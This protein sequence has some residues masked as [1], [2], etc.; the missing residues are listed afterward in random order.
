MTQFYKRMGL[1]A[2]AQR[3]TLVALVGA[4]TASAA[5]AQLGHTPSYTQNLNT[6]YTDL[7]TT[8]TAIATANNDDANSAEQ[9]IGFTFSFDGLVMDRFILNT[10]GFLKLG[11]AAGMAAPTVAQYTEFAQSNSGG[12]LLGTAA[13]DVELLSPFNYDL[14]NGTSPAEFRVAT[15]GTA[16][17][18]VCTVQ[19]KNVADK[20]QLTAAGGTSVANQYANLSFQVRMFETSNTIEFVYGPNTPAPAANND[21]KYAQVGIKGAGSVA[22][23]ILQVAKISATPW[24]DQTGVTFAN[25]PVMAGPVGAFNFRQAAPPDNGRT[26]RFAVPVPNDVAVSAIQGFASVIVPA[27]GAIT[28]RGVISNLG[29]AAQSVAIPVTLTISGANTYTATQRLV[30]LAV[31]ASGVVTFPGISLPNVGQNTVTLSVPSDGNN[32]NNTVAQPME[33][34][35]TTF[36]LATPGGG[37]LPTGFNPGTERY[38]A[39]KMTLNTPRSITAVSG[40]ITN[41]GNAPTSKESIGES[42][43]GVVIDAA[44]GALLGRSPN[45]VIMAADVNVLH[46]FTLSAPTTVPAGDVLVG[47]VLTASTGTLPYY[48]F[49]VQAEDPNRAGTYYIGTPGIAPTPALNV[50]GQTGYKFPFGAVTGAPANNDFSVNEIQAY[51]SIAVPAGNPVTL[52]AVVR[53]GGLLA[54]AAPLAVTLTVSGANSVTQTQ[55]VTSLAVGATT[56][57]TFTSLNLSSA[58]ANT[59][60]VT[61]PTDD[62]NAN[63]SMAQPMATSATRF[64]TIAPGGTVGGNGFGAPTTTVTRALCTKFTVNAACDVTAVRAFI[65][66]EPTLVTQSA[67]VFAVVLNATTG[68]VIARSRGDYVITPADLGQLHTFGLTARVPAGDFLVGLAQVQ[69]AGGLAFYPLGGQRETPSRAD[70]YYFANI[71]NPAPPITLVAGG[72]NGAS[73]ARLMLEAETSIVLATSEALKRAVSVFPNPSETGVFTLDIHGANAHQPMSVEV[74]NLLGQSMYE[75]TAQDNFSNAVDLSGLAAGIYSL[76]LRNGQQY[77]QQKIVIG[78]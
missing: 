35:A 42:V 54:L 9:L 38:Y 67:T 32:A 25:G 13:N 70:L 61:L 56:V 78:K 4:G 10:N 76:T 48:P 33:T 77:F 73:T 8:G 34:S 53:N 14:T 11:A 49:G 62:N 18:R 30:S 5:H 6:T 36:S 28:L 71:T 75:G 23:Q 55:T 37:A 24:G 39:A 17:N 15:T 52:R 68:A 41:T 44:T 27:S 47:M 66:A 51:G 2:C 65:P 59:I 57:V 40:L 60:T 29:S 7:G 3:V 46:T 22:T 1:L 43:Y 63:N 72:G 69:L 12:T 45:Y 50:A 20:A 19:W 64:S 31:G 16:P 74:V 26:Y 21:F 58:G